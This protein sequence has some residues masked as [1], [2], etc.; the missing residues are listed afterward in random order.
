[1]AQLSSRYSRF[2]FPFFLAAF[3]AFGQTPGNRYA[4]FLQDEPLAK[5]FASRAEL[6]ST[7]ATA[8]R[9]RIEAAQQ[10]VRTELTTR[11]IRITGSVSTLLNAIFVVMPAS[12]VAEVKGI[13]G[14]LEVAPVRRHDLFLNSATM[15]MNGPQAWNLTGGQSNAGA[16]IRIGILDSGVDQTHPALQDSSL[17]MPTGFPIC[18]G[19]SGASG[20]GCNAFTNSKVIVARSYVAALAEG[21]DP[22]NPAPDSRPDDYSPRDHIGHGTATASTAAG[23]TATGVVTINGMA[24]KAYIGNYKVF[25]SPTVNDGTYGDVEVMALDDALKDGMDIVSFS[26]GGPAFSGPLDTGAACNPA[27]AAGVPCDVA[28]AGF[29][30]AAQK[31]LTIVVAAGNG[32]NN[33][34]EYYPLYNSINTPGDAPSVITAGA[35]TNSHG[36]SGLV[37]VTGLNAM[38]SIASDSFASGGALTAPLVDVTTLGNDG[39]AC[40][41]LPGGALDNSTALIERG[42]AG[43]G[44]CTFATKMTNAVTAGAVGV[45][46]YMYNSNAPVQPQGLTGF[47]QTAAMIS[48]SDGLNLKNFIDANPGYQVTIDPA[49]VEQPGLA[50]NQLASFS[51][52]GPSLGLNGMKPEMLAVGES[53]YMPTQNYDILG[54]MFSSNRFIFAAG[55][56]FSTPLIAGSAALVKQNHPGYSGAQIKSALINTSAQNV[57]IDDQGSTVNI[58][59]TGAGQLV[60]D[61][62]IRTSVIASPATVSFGALS[63]GQ[64]PPSQQLTFTN[65]GS[66]SVTLALAVTGTGATVSPTSLP[67]AASASGTAALTVSGSGS[68]GIYNGAVTVQGGAVPLSIPWMFLVGTGA[69]S[70]NTNI[71]IMSGDFNDGTVN[72][73]IPDG[74]AAFQITDDYGVP[75]AGTRVSWTADAGVALSQTSTTTDAFGVA[76]ATVTMGAIAGQYSVYGCVA[77]ATCTSAFINNGGLGY[78]FTEYSRVT[79]SIT[80]AGVVNAMSYTQPVAPGSYIAIFGSGLYDPTVTA[81][82]NTFDIY[83][84]PRLPLALDYTMVSFD[85]PSADISVPGHIFFV[86]GGQ[87]NLQVPWELQGQKSAQVKVSIDYSYGNVVTVL[88]S[89]FAPALFSYGNFAAATNGAGVI[90]GSNPAARGQAITLYANGLGPVENQPASGEPA[91]LSVLSK[92]TPNTATVTIG[93]QPATVGFSGLAPGEIGVYQINVTVPNNIPAGT[94]N[95]VVSIGGVSSP[96]ATLPIQ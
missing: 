13:A 20:A 60:A 6:Q 73:M 9:Q 66:T 24:P 45:I 31:G 75:L 29:E 11:R 84:G 82:G 10:S 47:I 26:G 41:P 55:T 18:S 59:Q 96:T 43:S 5:R 92:T 86:S 67:L 16:G 85:V 70:N 27:L 72:Q 64:K 22:A 15:L 1:L 40:S 44:A 3:S 14:V 50:P 57:T 17:T 56:S 36:F 49:A 12:R 48:N 38:T 93:G 79:P 25:G 74:Q 63:P 90:T 54:G 53:L 23:N 88:L 42:P 52:F 28:A 77:V 91:S 34:W 30:T 78:A 89:D 51:S 46:F 69:V 32:G 94:Q 33:G 80:A 83:T 4:V 81:T 68:A 39:Y 58:L 95:V 65:T 71:Q 61:A 76:Y 21:S 8:Y 2:F 7:E 19:F 35:T 87:I 37:E 62:A